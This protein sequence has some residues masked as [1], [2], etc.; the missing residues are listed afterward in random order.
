MKTITTQTDV[1]K[2]VELSEDA[3]QSAIENLFDI[4]VD[5]EWWEST[6]DDAAE[7]GLK[8]TSFELGRGSK[9]TGEL[10]S[11][12]TCTAY[13]IIENHGEKCGTYQL[14]KT[15]L[16]DWSKLVEKYSDGVRLDIV[17]ED[18]DYEFDQ[19]ANDLENDFRKD[20]LED[21][22]ST[23][24]KECDYLM[25]RAAIVETIESNDYDFTV[26]GKLY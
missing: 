18:N 26:D 1:Y 13:K 4:N 25:S 8:I 16:S 14:A 24:T 7:I 23:L 17:A 11:S 9:I 6:Y 19:E 3:Q 21:Y 2:F 20:L 12:G 22:L 5:Y 15:F 10:T